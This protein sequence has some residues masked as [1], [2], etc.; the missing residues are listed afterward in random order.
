MIPNRL[1]ALHGEGLTPIQSQL[2]QRYTFRLSRPNGLLRLGIRGYAYT[3]TKN[4]IRQMNFVGNRQEDGRFEFP[5]SFHGKCF[6]DGD[7]LAQAMLKAAEKNSTLQASVNGRTLSFSSKSTISLLPDGLLR[8]AYGVVYTVMFR[9]RAPGFSGSK[10]NSG[11]SFKYSSTTQIISQNGQ[12][13]GTETVQFYNTS[14]QSQR[15]CGLS[16]SSTNGLTR[17]LDLD[18]FG[19]FMGTPALEELEPYHGQKMT[20]F[21]SAPLRL[22]DSEADIAYPLQ[23]YVDRKILA[24]PFHPQ[25]ATVVDVGSQYPTYRV[26]LPEDLQSKDLFIT[27]FSFFLNE[28]SFI[29]YSMNVMRSPDGKA[30]LFT[31]PTNVET[32]AEFLAIFDGIDAELLWIADTP[33]REYFTP[34][35]PSL[36]PGQI[37]ITLETVV[38]PFTMYFTYL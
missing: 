32:V 8:D 23:G 38:S 20:F 35:C 27:R 28:Q 33:V 24:R 31:T 29:Q 6:V 4:D 22:K 10:L 2:S 34:I 3:E 18:S 11:L 1:R 36:A 26:E 13:T 21:L 5:I 25:S 37:Y 30:F 17:E 15:L 16:V 14:L 9:M 19:V 7:M 12:F